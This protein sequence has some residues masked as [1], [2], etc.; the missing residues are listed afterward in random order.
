MAR[1]C[2]T[3]LPTV[4]AFLALLT[5]PLVC[6]AQVFVVGEK[7]ATEDVITEFHPTHV[8]LSDYLLDER[9]RQDL[10]R[11]LEAE[12]GFAHRELPLGAGLTLIANGNM[13]PSKEAYKQMLYEKGI[14]AGLGDR[15]VI[16]ALHFKPDSIVIDFNGGPYAKHRFLSHVYLNDTPLAIEGPIAT[17]CRVTLVFEGGVPQISAAEVKALLQPLVDFKARS[18]VEAYTDT[19][20]PQVRSAVEQH[21]VLVGMDRRMVLAALGPPLTKHREHVDPNDDASAVYEE[22][23]YG[24]MPQ[25]IQF[26]R[27]RGG[28]VVRLEIAAIGKPIEVRDKNEIGGP[29][30][31]ALLARNIN[32]GDAPTNTDTGGTRKPP[33]L[34]KPGEVLDTPSRV[35]KVNMPDDTPPKPIPPPPGTTPDPPPLPQFAPSRE[36]N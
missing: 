22:W 34:R 21:E 18:A 16:S 25:P 24:Q 2:P 10:I 17:G 7:T 1:S 11:N 3:P 15:M 23:I 36:S 31:P 4:A 20:T 12:Q 28:R 35:G 6:R 14:S 26:V 9:G 32:N 27:F 13:S 30:E 19:L 8:P 5:L 33:T 29:E